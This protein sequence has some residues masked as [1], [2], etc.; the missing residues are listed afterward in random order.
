[1]KSHFHDNDFLIFLWESEVMMVESGRNSYNS[2]S[3]NPEFAV[4]FTAVEC[5]FQKIKNFKHISTVFRRLS[6]TLRL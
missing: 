6:I 2:F 3:D 1:M 4:A 5:F